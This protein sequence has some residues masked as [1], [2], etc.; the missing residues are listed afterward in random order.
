[1]AAKLPAAQW[2]KIK[3]DRPIQAVVFVIKCPYHLARYTKR[4]AEGKR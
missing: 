4:Q 1:M 3:L 2:L